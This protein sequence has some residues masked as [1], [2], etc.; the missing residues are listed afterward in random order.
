VI[1]DDHAVV[2]ESLRLLLEPETDLSVVGETGDLAGT[3]RALRELAPT[4]L[5]LDLHKGREG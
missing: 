2:R 4:V 3:L 5:V 1:A